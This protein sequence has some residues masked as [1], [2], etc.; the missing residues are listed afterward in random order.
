MESGVG[1]LM[2]V[3]SYLI[4]TNYYYLL[5]KIVN[6]VFLSHFS[7]WREASLQYS[8]SSGGDRITGHR[9]TADTDHLQMEM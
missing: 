7:F 8:G 6:K 2:F 9:I 3:T 5:T 4:L 1:S